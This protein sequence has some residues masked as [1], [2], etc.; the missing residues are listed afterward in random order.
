MLISDSQFVIAST[1]AVVLVSSIVAG[2]TG[3]GFGLVTI[4][5]MMLWLSPKLV[6]PISI[7]LG[8]VSRLV[9]GIGFAT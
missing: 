3:F 8:I 9:L 6:V 1:S 4:P 2:L 7:L 5:L